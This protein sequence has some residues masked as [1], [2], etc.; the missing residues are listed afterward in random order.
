MSHVHYEF[1]LRPLPYE[2]D[3]LEF[4]IGAQTVQ[5]HHDKHNKGPIAII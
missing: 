1:I 4:V 5:L 2:Y 3:F